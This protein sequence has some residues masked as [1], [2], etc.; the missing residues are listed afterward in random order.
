MSF[1]FFFFN[2]FVSLQSYSKKFTSY[3][4]SLSPHLFTKN[5]KKHMLKWVVQRRRLYGN[6][7]RIETPLKFNKR[8][9]DQR[10]IRNISWS[11][12]VEI[13]G[14]YTRN[15]QESVMLHFGTCGLGNV[16][17]LQ[18]ESRCEVSS[19]LSIPHKPHPA[20]TP[21]LH[22]MDQRPRY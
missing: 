13:T 17:K 2:V 16:V 9:N 15:N 20:W 6:D 11:H 8:S 14:H 21:R 18:C 7:N 12:A 1:F 19:L 5:H 22:R 4:I 10:I 3:R